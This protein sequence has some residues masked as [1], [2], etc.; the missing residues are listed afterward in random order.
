MAEAQKALSDATKKGADLAIQ[1][2]NQAVEIDRYR[3]GLQW[4]LNNLTGIDHE[5]AKE[6]CN[7]ARQSLNPK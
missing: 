7:I 4:V 2:A 1:V 3:W 5:W 6:A